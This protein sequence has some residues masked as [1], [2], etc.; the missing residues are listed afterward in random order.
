MPTEK[1]F[2][3][4]DDRESLAA[5]VMLDEE[6]ATTLTRALDSTSVSTPD[7]FARKVNVP[8]IEPATLAKMYSVLRS[9]YA[10]RT[11]VRY[12]ESPAF[13]DSVIEAMKNSGDPKL[14]FADDAVE[15]VRARLTTLLSVDTFSTASKT[16]SLA[17]DSQR[18]LQNVSILTDLRPVFHESAATPPAG[19][20]IVHTLKIGYFIFDYKHE[21]D[22]YV[23][24][25]EDQ[26]R[27]IQL[28]VTRALQ[29]SDTL[30]A[31]LRDTGLTYL[32]RSN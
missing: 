11:S 17:A 8:N 9:L 14:A 7:E 4:K 28:A 25:T 3:P 18:L 22:F 2:I 13:V 5:L 26:L 19:F 31:T 12:N 30:H 10:T 29:K 23:A 1:L 6:S 24:V 20:I 15:S 32:D 21:E 27:D 16:K